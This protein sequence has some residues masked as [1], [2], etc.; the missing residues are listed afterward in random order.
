[1]NG[2]I[3]LELRNV[4]TEVPVDGG[5][6]PVVRDV[7]F[8]VRRGEVVGLVGES[9]SGKSMTARSILRLLPPG[10]RT[11]GTI[12]FDGA[13]VLEADGARLRALR[14]RRIAMIFQDPRAH[15]DPLYRCGDHLDD[16]LKIHLGLGAAAARNRSFELLSEVGIVEPERVY[17]AY[18]GE[19]SGGMLQRIVIAGALA[20][21]PDLLIADEPTTALDVTI[22]AE[23]IAILD[24][25]R[26]ERHVSA[27][28][29]THDLELA[30]TI[31]DRILV[32]YAGR[33]LEARSTAQLFAGPLH[34]YTAGLLRARPMLESR[35]DRLE[36]IPGRPPRIGEAGDGCP[37]APRC[38]YVEDACEV[39]PPDLRDAGLGQQTACWRSEGLATSLSTAAAGS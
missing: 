20:V 30:S 17:R 29:I 2:D 34:P 9:G 12:L 18:P 36:T 13:D 38:A 23:I 11:R 7:S 16:A 19:L 8:A 31:C 24:G 3:L 35:R 5:F 27:V 21:E 10:G 25:L 32:M 33:V 1:M 22:Q 15:V 14:A 6:V 28:F 39:R 26:R 4:V 37:F